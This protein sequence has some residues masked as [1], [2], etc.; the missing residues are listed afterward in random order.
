MDIADRKARET[1]LLLAEKRQNEAELARIAAEKVA[2]TLRADVADALAANDRR[3]RSMVEAVRDHAFFTLDR[4]GV[5]TSWNC[6]AERLLGYAEEAIVGRNVACIFTPEDNERGVPQKL[7]ALAREAVCAED[8]G[9]RVKGDGQRMWARVTKSAQLDGAGAVT[10]Y[11]V[12]LED[13]TERRKLAAV[14]EETRLER[15]RLQ[16]K[17]LS[18]VS[19]ELRTPLTALHF[20]VGNVADGVLG[21]V[22]PEQREH[23][24][25]AMENIDQLKDMVG[26]LLDIT[27]VDTHKLTVLPQHTS[28]ARLIAEALSTCRT[29]TLA[30]SIRLHSEIAAELPWAWADPL[31]VRQVLINLIDNAAK[32][33]GEGGSIVVGARQLP[34]DQG[35]LCV[36]VSDTGCGIARADREII[37]DRLAQLEQGSEVSR[38][39]LGIGLFIAREL[40]QQHG[41]RIWVESEPGQGSTFFFTLPVFSIAKLCAHVLTP[42]NLASGCA[43]L[44]AV[45]VVVPDRSE[46]EE[47]L[48]VVHEV[49][50]RCVHPG[51]DV[52]LPWMSDMEEV[53][54]FFIAACT[55]SKGFSV[56]ANRIGMELK[57]LDGSAKL[58]PYISSTTVV[59]NPGVPGEDLIDEVTARFEGLIEEHL[60]GQEQFQ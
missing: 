24:A 46:R 54:T 11:A 9:W 38:G 27:R 59:L 5:V 13:A 60:Q 50:E 31:R 28:L 43:T 30:K 29:I 32:F 20:F 17:F 15:M 26:D 47:L 40:V 36:S 4:E 8:E 58:K 22:S 44:I 1:A 52:L 57:H 42:Q 45:D 7:I 51:Q 12:I 25:L 53:T 19:H 37:F 14:V 39:G 55:D 33:T 21:E 3:F 34:G 16:E 41:G 35:F 56:I 6:G 23:L 49:L 2:E 48:P 10:G 18:N